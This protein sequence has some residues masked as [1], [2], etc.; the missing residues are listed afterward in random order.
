[1]PPMADTALRQQA[2]RVVSG[3][4]YPS[5]I[6]DHRVMREKALTCMH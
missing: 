3:L 4:P 6:V 5:P 1:M 2:L